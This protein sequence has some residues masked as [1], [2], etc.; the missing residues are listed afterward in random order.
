M[1]GK[2]VNAI[3][4]PIFT[5]TVVAIHTPS[6]T[7]YGT[8]T[9][10]DG[11]FS[12]RNMRVGGPYIVRVS[13]IGYEENTESD[14]FL[15]LNK[16]AD[17]NV[18]L[19]ERLVAL[20]EVAILYNK[21]DV[22]NSDRTG[23]MTNVSR[24]EIRVLPTIKRSQQDLTRLTPESDGNSF[25]GRN[26]LYNN[27]SLDGSI[28]NNPFG[29]DYA[30]PGGQTDAQPVSLDAIDQ[31]QVSLAP[32]DV[33]EG[34][35][36]G[37]G[38]NAVTKSGTNEIRGT[39]YYFFRNEN[40]IGKKIGNVE[41]PNLDFETNLFGATIGGPIARNRLFFFLSVEGERRNELAHGWVAQKSSN[42]GQE[43]VTSVMES[44]I[45]AVQDHFRTRWGYN[46]GDYQGYYHRTFNNKLLA[47]LNWNL[48]NNHNAVFRYN[49]LDSWKDILPHTEAIGGRGPT[50]FRLPFANSSYRIYNRIHSLVG[51][52]NSIFSSKVSNKLMIGY[53][54]FRD[55]RI[56]HSSAFPVIDIYDAN[57]NIAITAGSEMFS[58]HNRLYQDVFQF[59]DNVTIYKEKHTLTAGVNLEI[60]RFENSF[61]LFY[62]PN[63]GYQSVADFLSNDAYSI[64]L[65]NYQ[66]DF[67]Q[68]VVDSQ[69]NPYNWSYVDVGQ[70]AFYLQ[71]EFAVSDKLNLTFGLRVDLPLYFNEIEK[72][73][74]VQ[75]VTD[76]DGWVNENGDA[77]QVDPSQWPKTVLLWSPRLGFNYDVK[78][79]KRL[80][81]RG[82]TGIFS[83][84]IPFV[85][86]G[87]QSSNPGIAATSPSD[88]TF[89]VNDTDEK[90]HWPQ[91][92]KT[93]L[94]MDAKAGE[95]W[96][97]TLEGIYGKDINAI[98][99]RN[100]N[101]RAPSGQ[102]TG[103]GDN[104]A[105]FAGFP[106][107]NIY[108]ADANTQGFLD[109]GTIVLNNVREGY[110]A[111]I[112]GKV[113]KRWTG[114][115][116]VSVAYSYLSSKDY[117][118]IPA[119][120]AAD[121]FQRSPVVGNPNFPQFSWSRYGLTHR[122][123]G[124]LFYT[125]SY[126]FMASSLGVF[127]EAGQ[128]NR[129]SFAYA[130]DL[131]LDNIPNNDLIY[132][133]Q[134]SGDINFGTV[135]N[136]V[137]VP[138]DNA[139]AQWQALDA[140]IDQDAYLKERRG[141]YADRNGVS[142]PWFTQLDLRYMHDFVLKGN[143]TNHTFQ[144]SID[145]L[146]FGNM[147]S[148]TWGVIKL[149]RTMTPITVN[150]VDN[151][152]VPWFQFDTDLKNSYVDD[153]SVASKWQ[154]QIGIRYIFN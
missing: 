21:N 66:P 140:F 36:T 137:G 87:N 62:Y 12:I 99:H 112:T 71:D 148:S 18:T 61:N 20:E 16:T 124:S 152:N 128:G 26:N 23:A 51:E 120:I 60:F 105:V 106:E 54:A 117:T 153:F 65:G 81:I 49:M 28:F 95:G 78:G 122:I 154:L 145:I 90:F 42:A 37:A 116:S 121:A 141:K 35:F 25:G 129:Y 133:P 9:R 44:D 72:T 39:V 130:G 40:M 149:P 103:T 45:Q 86:L 84:R 34:G 31:I 8:I 138:A 85:W 101:M 151:S 58:T 94:A 132:V 79:D 100:Y 5:A 47:K 52:V 50:S 150:G 109:A 59:T 2:V 110:Q 91:V 48:F 143:K 134:G 131:N 136:G 96:I 57:N 69:R 107:V 53:T 43:N 104:R 77:V 29:L 76:Y 4:E 139:S 13:Y 82:G 70:L 24:E 67:N 118:S 14:I 126:S 55:S 73:D 142:L 97:F 123:V 38:V 127:F 63:H 98:V 7:Q 10:H 115:L 125:K 46:P 30:V 11:R 135:E 93:N 33:T 89:Q 27:F 74:A 68:D 114:G 83:G 75:V 22:I 64:F 108:S 56:P 102:L 92:W 88:Y 19:I 3:D 147:F 80:Q 144:V 146:N 119:E 41:V 32:F 6:G 15:Q 113:I 111:S 17:I 1:K